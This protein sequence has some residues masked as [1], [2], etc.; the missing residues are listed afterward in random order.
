MKP[1]TAMEVNQ[2]RYIYK[3]NKNGQPNKFSLAAETNNRE[4]ILCN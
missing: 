2:N 4:K 3:G 1:T